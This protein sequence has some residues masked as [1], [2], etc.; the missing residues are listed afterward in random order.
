[1]TDSFS[2]SDALP[3]DPPP[4]PLQAA[5]R[6]H[7]LDRG[8]EV[9]AMAAEAARIRIAWAKLVWLL[10]F[11][12]ACCWRSVI[13]CPTSPSKRN[14]P[15]RAVSSEPNTIL[16]ATTLASRRLAICREP[17]KWFRRSSAPASYISIRR[18]A[19]RTSRRSPR[20]TRSRIPTEGQGSGVIME[21][22]G[23]ILTNNHVIKGASDIQVSLA[24]GR[25][26]KAQR[27]RPRWSHRSGRA[28]DRCR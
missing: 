20:R 11:L 27:R 8:D 23:Y 19:K 2:N 1:M 26:I 25:K 22:R 13:W 28:E 18:A 6:I 3:G 12:G 10:A 21:D 5:A 9:R 15:R 14:M 24:D 7:P 17:I 16:P 4:P